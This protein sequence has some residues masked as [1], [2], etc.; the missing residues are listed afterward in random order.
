MKETHERDRG[1]G[2]RT[3]RWATVGGERPKYELEVPGNLCVISVVRAPTSTSRPER[4]RMRLKQILGYSRP[5]L[6]LR[7]E[8]S[9]DTLE[10]QSSEQLVAPFG[11]RFPWLVRDK[12][13]ASSPAPDASYVDREFGSRSA[14]CAPSRRYWCVCHMRESCGTCAGICRDTC[15][16]L[17]SNHTSSYKFRLLGME[18]R[19]DCCISLRTVPRTDRRRPYQPRTR[20]FARGP[21]VC[22]ISAYNQTNTKSARFVKESSLQK[23]GQLLPDID[24]MAFF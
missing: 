15:A 24:M 4:Y 16:Q 18:R 8:S 11:W 14:V 1:T 3:S 12:A 13:A 22:L 10:G 20:T 23:R 6:V 21:T 17:L 7:Q 5:E 19:A 9:L 2:R